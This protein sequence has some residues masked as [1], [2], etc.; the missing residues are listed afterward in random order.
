MGGVLNIGALSKRIDIQA[1][2]KV[3]DLMGGFVVSW[4]TLATSIPAALWPVSASEQVKAMGMDVTISHRIKM[5]YRANMRPSF[6]I[7]YGNR[8]FNIVSII[9]VGEQN[10]ELDVLCKEAG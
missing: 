1:P 10:K 7:R 2:T 9:N 6:R 8:Y 4:S 3:S 5:R